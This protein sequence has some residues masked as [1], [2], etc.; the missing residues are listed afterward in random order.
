MSLYLSEWL[1]G[2]ETFLAFGEECWCPE[3]FLRRDPLIPNH[4]FSSVAIFDVT[5]VNALLD[6]LGRN[7]G[8]KFLQRFNGANSYLFEKMH[9]KQFLADNI[10]DL[11][12]KNE[13]DLD[14]T[15][16]ELSYKLNQH[17]EEF[18]FW[19]K[20]ELVEVYANIIFYGTIEFPKPLIF[21]L[22]PMKDWDKY[23][24]GFADYDPFDAGDV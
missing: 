17:I 1:D 5:S 21:F 23:P 22:P 20:L 14:D 2:Y 16:F 3:V 12:I 7:M 6:N 15:S 19:N 13:F 10:Q 18:E 8:K 24:N 11:L 9:I 4:V